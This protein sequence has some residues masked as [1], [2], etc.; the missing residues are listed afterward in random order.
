M[1]VIGQNQF[2]CVV[3]QH[4]R[5]LENH[6]STMLRGTI[7]VSQHESK[8]VRCIFD[9]MVTHYDFVETIKCSF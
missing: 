4:N 1:H 3:G 8:H 9:I 7:R 5:I 6:R 2:I